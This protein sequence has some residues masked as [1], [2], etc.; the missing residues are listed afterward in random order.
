MAES[1]IASA[2][3]DEYN[4]QQISET[5]RNGGRNRRRDAVSIN[6]PNPLQGGGVVAEA[7]IQAAIDA[8]LSNRGLRSGFHRSAQQN[9]LTGADGGFIAGKALDDYHKAEREYQEDRQR[10]LGH[11]TGNIE[12]GDQTAVDYV[13]E[14]ALLDHEAQERQLQGLEPKKYVKAQPRDEYIPA[15]LDPRASKSDIIRYFISDEP[16]DPSEEQMLISA[17]VQK[18][19]PV[20]RELVEMRLG[21]DYD[22]LSEDAL[23][24]LELYDPDGFYYNGE[25]IQEWRDRQRDMEE[26][27][28]SYV[29]PDF[30]WDSVVAED[31]STHPS[32]DTVVQLIRYASSKIQPSSYEAGV[33]RQAADGLKADGRDVESLV[34]RVTGDVFA[35]KL[36]LEEAIGFV[37]QQVGAHAALS[38]VANLRIYRGLFN[39]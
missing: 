32:P 14:Q 12:V 37:E 9:T 1:Y 33:Y 26:T 17:S 11:K 16:L 36:N 8:D 5:H 3:V 27:L 30:E 21:G 6:K 29:R 18:D 15:P 28:D 13:S 23:D 19:D 20:F 7:A 2:A 10:L 38:A 25:D 31:P 34:A 24:F 39:I 22:K 4:R 35:G